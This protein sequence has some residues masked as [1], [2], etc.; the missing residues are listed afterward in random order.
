MIYKRLEDD[1]KKNRMLF[2]KKEEI[3]YNNDN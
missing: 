1:N 3:C 2:A